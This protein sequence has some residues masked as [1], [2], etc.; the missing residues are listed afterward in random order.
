MYSFLVLNSIN[1]VFGLDLSSKQVLYLTIAILVLFDPFIIYDVGFL[2]SICTVGGIILCNDFIQDNNKFKSAFKLSLIAFLFSLPISLY[3][4]YE[5]NLLSIIY[6]IV[7]IPFISIIVYPLSLLSFVFPFLYKLFNISLDI[8]EWSS[9]V[10]SSFKIFN[11][12][13]S[14]NIFEVLLFYLGLYLIFVK[15][16]KIYICLLFIIVIFDYLLPYLDKNNYVYFLDVG[17]GDASLIITRNRKEVILLDIGGLTDTKVSDRYISLLKYLGIKNVD[18][19]ILTQGDFDHM[20]DAINVIN[21]FNIRNV[22][23]NCGDFN[24]L[25]LSYIKYLDDKGIKYYSCINDLKLNNNTLYFLNTKIYDN[26][27]DNSNVIYTKFNNYDFLFMGDSEI[28]R[29]KDLVAYFDLPKID[30]LKVGHHGSKTSS[31]KKFINL[32]KP[33]YSIISVGKY[34]KY[35]HPNKEVL[36]NLK[37]SKIYRTDQDGSV[38]ITIGKRFKINSYNP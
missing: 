1:K 25:E 14:F 32:I 31:N 36:E 27:N 9:S 23:F 21:T 16:H 2:F 35:G 22:I 12:Y 30:I 7:F 38:L 4:F 28:N 17:Q 29:E 26:E 19:L 5:I 37:D 24:E 15:Q 6:N 10:L 34:N 3:S 8:L 20:G 18:Y 33:N 11:L 13:L